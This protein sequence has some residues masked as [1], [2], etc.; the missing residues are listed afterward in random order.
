MNY[1]KL[2]MRTVLARCPPVIDVEGAEITYLLVSTS[3]PELEN[4]LNCSPAHSGHSYML[5]V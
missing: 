1:Q 3:I 4:K 2:K 5:H